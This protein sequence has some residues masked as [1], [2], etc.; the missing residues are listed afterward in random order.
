MNFY[1]EKFWISLDNRKSLFS[2]ELQL[3]F[4]IRFFVRRENL[5]VF[6]MVHSTMRVSNVQSHLSP[7][8]IYSR[9]SWKFCG[10]LERV[11]VKRMPHLSSRA[12]LA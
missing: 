1:A 11:F 9:V 7:I 8:F 6:W 10:I 12:G 3:P 5:R 4:V 2:E